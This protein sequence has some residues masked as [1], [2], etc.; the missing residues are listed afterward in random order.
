MAVLPLEA[1]DDGC[2]GLRDVL[3]LNDIITTSLQYLKDTGLVV[4]K[5]LI[6]MQDMLLLTSYYTKQLP[7]LCNR[8]SK[9]MLM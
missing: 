2:C 5:G 6:I 7:T 4:D 8:L 9:A 1:C 3:L